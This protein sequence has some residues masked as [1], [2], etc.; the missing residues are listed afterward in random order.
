M[1]I[2]LPDAGEGQLWTESVTP[3][4][5]ADVA[6]EI[7]DGLAEMQGQ[8]DDLFVSTSLADLAASHRAEAERR[9]RE[10]M[11]LDPDAGLIAADGFARSVK[12]VT[13]EDRIRKQAQLGRAERAAAALMPL[14][15]DQPDA[16]DEAAARLEDLGRAIRPLA[17]DEA[18]DAFTAA[19]KARL[20]DSALSGLGE[21]APDMAESALKGGAFDGYLDPAE[22]RRRLKATTDSAAARQV[23]EG[24]VETRLKAE[25][26]RR[27]QAQALGFATLFT[28][29][30][31][32]GE[33][34]LTEELVRAEADGIL[35]P[36][37]ASWLR[38]RLT[39]AETVR[40]ERETRAG[41]IAAMLEGGRVLDPA[42][43]PDRDDSAVHFDMVVGP[44][45]EGQ[46]PLAIL[47]MIRGYTESV[48]IT[49]IPAIN[50]LRGMLIA[51]E[52]D[53]RVGVARA[54]EQLYESDPESFHA[55]SAGEQ[56]MA[57]R[58]FELDR[59]NLPAE[60]AVELAES[61]PE[62]SLR[63]DSVPFVTAS[64]AGAPEGEGA[65][66]DN[67]VDDSEGTGSPDGLSSG[68]FRRGADRIEESFD[69]AEDSEEASDGGSE[70]A[71][72][73]KTKVN[74]PLTSG[75]V[76]RA[77][78][79]IADSFDENRRPPREVDDDEDAR[80]QILREQ[81]ERHEKA[82]ETK[83]REREM[84]EKAKKASEGKNRPGRYRGPP[85]GG[86]APSKQFNCPGGYCPPWAMIF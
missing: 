84:K 20:A 72:D 38:K 55:L 12:A 36:A 44:N 21:L 32:A 68:D 22:K 37:Q 70:P 2:R 85:G 18:A 13:A 62:G 5:L 63:A 3:D 14:V 66:A 40:T 29:R 23:D 53:E 48:G 28:V 58:L 9:Q 52:P 61:L 83:E 42:S 60:K 50:R 74:N 82:R 1:V 57:L 6:P 11:A 75:T 59:L 65:G 34:A 4:P 80:K 16:L 31:A 49:P 78:D 17:G 71:K 76:R 79:R 86:G 45:L 27:Q 15:R 35:A 10:A 69:R 43:E 19:G 67:D 41:R 46:E 73:P 56:R 8:D 54:Y 25:R 81:Q 30:L 7:R 33:A 64:E 26:A 77:G 39:E 47:D 24:I 51:G